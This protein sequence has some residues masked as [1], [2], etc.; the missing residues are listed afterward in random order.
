VEEKPNF[1]T[2]MKLKRLPVIVVEHDSCSE[3][4]RE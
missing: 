2:L 4:D 1:F 3:D